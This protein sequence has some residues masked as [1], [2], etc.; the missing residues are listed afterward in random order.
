LAGAVFL[1]LPYFSK[2]HQT[3]NVRKKEMRNQLGKDYLMLKSLIIDP[4][5]NGNSL[6]VNQIMKDFF[7]IQE[8][9]AMPYTGLLLLDRDKQVAHAYSIKA[10]TEAKGMIGSSYTGIEFK[11]SEE[12]LHKVLTLYRADKEHPMGQKGMEVAFELHKNYALIGWLL[13]QLDV[14]FFEKRYDVHA[15]DLK[16]LH[17]KKP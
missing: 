3:A 16:S 15:E 14:D 2:S 4:F 10:D 11:G 1:G 7:N 8:T 6:R 13:F 9:S 12:S 17:F 5:I